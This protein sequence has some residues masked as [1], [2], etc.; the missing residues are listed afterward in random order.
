MLQKNRCLAGDLL[1]SLLILLCGAILL[2]PESRDLFLQTT[3][4]HAY[5][6]GFF[7]FF[8]LATMGD[9][10]GLRIINKRWRFPQGFFFKACLWGLMGMAIT[11]L[12]SVY[13]E[14]VLGAMSLK[15]L[16]FENIGL[17][18]A[19]FSSAIMNLTFGPML[20]I[21]HKFGELFIDMKYENKGGKVA[22]SAL[23]ERMDWNTMV[24]FSW[25]KTC[26][27]MWI[28]L[29]TIVF[30]LPTQYRVVVSAFLSVFLGALIAFSKSKR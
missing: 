24:C 11:L 18:V 16:P 14:G 28:P 13:H 19:F 12:M 5:I 21:Y 25:L 22:L 2:V 3:E 8:V 9:L 27:L 7:K 10:L 20:Y 15:R 23:V 17:A 4:S 6:S 1:W 30:L 26:P 29:H